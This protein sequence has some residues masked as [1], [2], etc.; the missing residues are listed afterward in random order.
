MGA[1]FSKASKKAKEEEKKWNDLQLEGRSKY[2]TLPASF[3]RKVAE[4][5]EDDTAPISKT[6]TLPRNSDLRRN[7]S[8]SK[9]VRKSI[10]SWASQKG[11][12]DPCKV[13]VGDN[14]T[15]QSQDSTK[16]SSVVLGSEECKDNIADV[17][18][19]DELKKKESATPTKQE[20]SEEKAEVI[21]EIKAE[22]NGE[23]NA[24]KSPIEEQS[25]VREAEEN[26]ITD[27]VGEDA[28]I[29]TTEDTNGKEDSESD[30]VIV[31]KEDVDEECDESKKQ[32]L[33]E[34][35]V[36][37]NDKQ[38]IIEADKPEHAVA[39]TVEQEQVVSE[40]LEEIPALPELKE[41]N[42][43]QQEVETTETLIEQVEHEEEKIDVPEEALQTEPE[44]MIDPLADDKIEQNLPVDEEEKIPDIEEHEIAEEQECPTETLKV[45]EIEI[46][47]EGDQ[48]MSDDTAEIPTEQEAVLEADE[49]EV[50]VKMTI[51]DNQ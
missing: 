33:I 18:I 49:S 1:K 2:S 27:I 8:F 40:K 45:E 13:K 7:P 43:T 5:P 44:I 39:E 35:P 28:K 29:N 32:E 11:F 47:E 10:R 12:V 3:R 21:V 48:H 26:N 38:E 37:T 46:K 22:V 41:D 25:V 23:G 19:T 24:D 15:T 51:G 36:V 50:E 6:G 9:R 14:V 17:E 42:E 4:Q 16:P 34:E 31:K 30:F 20:E